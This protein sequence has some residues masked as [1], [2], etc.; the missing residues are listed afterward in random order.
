MTSDSVSK[1]KSGGMMNNSV[2]RVIDGLAW[3]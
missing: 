2:E 3:C 1:I